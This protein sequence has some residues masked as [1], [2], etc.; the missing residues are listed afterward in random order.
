MNVLRRFTDTGEWTTRRYLALAGNI[1]I[2]LI[3]AID[4]WYIWPTQLGGSTSMVV[5]S[6][7]SMEPTYFTGDLVIARRMEPSIGDVIVYAPEGLGGSQIV[8]RIIGGNATDGWQMQGDNND[9]IDP[10]TP[11][12]SEV[13]GVVLVHYSNFGRVTVLLLNPI[14]WAGMLLLAIVLLLWWSDDCEDDEDDDASGDE[15]E[16][17][18]SPGEPADADADAASAADEPADAEPAH[19]AP[20]AMLA[21][22]AWRSAPP[23]H[24]TGRVAAPEEGLGALRGRTAA[25]VVAALVGAGLVAAPAS[26]SSL[27]I[28][29]PENG[30]HLA[31]AHCDNL[32]LA[33]TA[34]G[35]HTG[36]TYSQVTVTGS[37]QACAGLPTTFTMYSASGAV[38]ATVS[39]PAVAGTQTFNVGSYHASQ[40]A[41]VV[42]V[43]DGWPFSVAWTA[44]NPGNPAPPAPGTCDGV[45]MADNTV[46][47]GTSC[48]L[49]GTVRYS[50]LD[51]WNGGPAF[52]GSVQANT[53][54]GP[55][56]YMSN[57]GWVNYQ[58]ITYWRFTLNLEAMGN[59]W[60]MGD[61]DQGFYLYKNGN[62]TALA[63]DEDCSDPHSVTFQEEV[64]SSNPS[65][66]F[67]V[68]PAPI[69]W[70]PASDLLCQGPQ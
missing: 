14:V 43:I 23:R 41:L 16:G 65:A 33:A 62:N 49:T 58:D 15:A 30:A 53:A 57:S 45:L 24:S 28:V 37:T 10:F 54:F 59:A 6:G 56:G 17:A 68:S 27:A 52:Y 4:A 19:S 12:G 11:S 35:S 66:S 22:F 50:Y 38:L 3:V 47:T 55:G 31:Y 60:V 18:A 29:A 1:I 7:T 20:S 26:A 2:W 40:V 44:P 70:K 63:P 39:G 69:L 48:T 32:A 67:I 13:K 8:H 9:F 21:A 61:L 36:N 34:A 46:V 64:A 51:A 25:A 42:A 5:V